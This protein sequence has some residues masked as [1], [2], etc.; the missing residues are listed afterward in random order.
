MQSMLKYK[1]EEINYLKEE[2]VFV[3]G[4]FREGMNDPSRTAAQWEKVKG[5]RKVVG[6][7]AILEDYIKRVQAM[8]DNRLQ[9]NS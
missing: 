6:R 9:I 2:G 4:E 8:K 7:K 1:V 3:E 5:I